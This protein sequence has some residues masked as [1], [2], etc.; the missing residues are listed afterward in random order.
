M[1]SHDTPGRRDPYFAGHFFPLLLLLLLLP[2]TGEQ[3]RARGLVGRLDWL[4]STQSLTL[5]VDNERGC[6]GSGPREVTGEMVAHQCRGFL[7]ACLGPLLHRYAASSILSPIRD[8]QTLNDDMAFFSP[9][10]SLKL[11]PGVK[12]QHKAPEE[13]QLACTGAA[14]RSSV[15][16]TEQE[17]R[18]W[19]ETWGET[20]AT[21]G[22]SPCCK[23]SWRGLSRVYLK[24]KRATFQLRGQ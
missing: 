4:K 1:A 12:I 7:E 20:R 24:L 2:I 22:R 15:I 6:A 18:T 14:L 10:R 16:E 17:A 3:R 11:T 23:W 19:G 9:R 8:A 5:R 13:L 21:P